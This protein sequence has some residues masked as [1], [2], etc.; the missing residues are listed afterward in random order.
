MDKYR[1]YY[2]NKLLDNYSIVNTLTQKHIILQN[3]DPL[4]HKLF[5]EDIF[6]IQSQNVIIEH[7]PTR[8]GNY[9]SGY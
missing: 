4:T 1:I 8:I 5:H 2:T 3:F 6:H 9:I 7:S